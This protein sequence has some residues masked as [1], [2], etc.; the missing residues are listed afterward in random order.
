MSHPDPS[1]DPSEETKAEP[2]QILSLGA[3]VQSSCLLLMASNGEVDRPMPE[4]ALFADTKNEPQEVYDHLKRLIEHSKITIEVLS[5]G[6]LRKDTIGI[7]THQ[8]TG[9]K[10]MKFLVPVFLDF[11]DGS[12]PGMMPH[13]KCTVDYKISVINKRL[14]QMVDPAVVRD[15]QKDRR[16]GQNPPPLVD[17]WVGISTDE[18]QR[19]KEAYQPWIN[20]VWP[21]IDMKMS[22]QDCIKK[23]AEYGWEAPR[24]ACTFCPFHDSRE[25]LRLQTGD[26]QSFQ[27][28]VE[29]EREMQDTAKLDTKL[30]GRP[31]L[32]SSCKPLN[33]IDFK[34]IVD[35][36]DRQLE[37]SF[38]DECEGMCGV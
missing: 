1:Y 12:A 2:L 3:G 26:P 8:K 33:E 20:N 25:W 31:Y 5:K 6:D 27:A 19:M 24:S 16:S 36:G 14:R 32:H 30:R 35:R 13:R 18:I 37:F 17:V 9:R 4:T 10:Y 22:R 11:Q 23:M 7:K 28:A 15:W 29:F 38:L 34:A 21:L